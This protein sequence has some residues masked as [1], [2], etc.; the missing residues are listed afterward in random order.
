MIVTIADVR[1]VMF[2]ASGARRWF[3]SY[4]FDFRKFLKDGMTVEELEATGDA[5]AYRVTKYV[6]EKNHG[7]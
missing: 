2:C 7:R 5:L 1:A 4:G 6:K 3:E